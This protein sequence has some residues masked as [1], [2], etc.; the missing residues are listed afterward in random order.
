[1]NPVLISVDDFGA[2][3]GVKR[4]KAYELLQLA[5]APQPVSIGPKTIR[6][7]YADAVAF[8]DS[9]QTG[10]KQ[11]PPRLK[12]RRY[13]NARLIAAAPDLLKLAD[14]VARLN[15][16]AG[17]IGAG[18]LAQLVSEARAAIAKAEDA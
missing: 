5:G 15:P 12:S 14:R 18:M 4:T 13:K 16:D 2:L 9:L 1:M 6:Y 3:F 10:A 7:R 8:L 11:E 17:E